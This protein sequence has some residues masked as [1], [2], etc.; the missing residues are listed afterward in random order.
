MTAGNEMKIRVNDFV[1]DGIIISLE[2]DRD[3]TITRDPGA[4]SQA[5]AAQCVGVVLPGAQMGL[6]IYPIIG[7]IPPEIYAFLLVHSTSSCV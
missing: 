7:S 4:G 3:V 1:R 2:P 5:D 6:G